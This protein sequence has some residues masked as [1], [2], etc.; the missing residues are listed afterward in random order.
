ML[1]QINI[2]EAANVFHIYPETGPKKVTC[3]FPSALYDDAVSAVG[4]RVEVFGT[5]KYR[6]RAT[7]PHEIAVRQIETF[8]PTH[9]LPDWEDLRG[10]APDATGGLPSEVF[11]RGLRDGWR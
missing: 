2:H 5:L 8:P 7:F 10:R 9:E 3:R 11:V 4:K 6:A 1:E